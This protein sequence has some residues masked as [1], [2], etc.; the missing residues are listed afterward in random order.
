MVIDGMILNAGVFKQST[1]QNIWSWD[2]E[3]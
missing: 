3:S 2:E 1:E